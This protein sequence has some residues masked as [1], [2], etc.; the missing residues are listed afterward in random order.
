[1]KLT[2]KAQMF[3]SLVIILLANV[4]STILKHW[5]YRSGGFVICGLLWLI[6]PVLPKGAEVSKRTL[7]WTRIAGVIL[8]LIGVFTRAYV[9]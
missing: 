7:L 5:I 6:H 8:I 9:Y 1:M 3:I 2:Y 4:I